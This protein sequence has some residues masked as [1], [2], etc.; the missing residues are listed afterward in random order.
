MSQTYGN[1]YTARQKLVKLN[2]QVNKIIVKITK[3]MYLGQDTEDGQQPKHYHCVEI[4]QS[5]AWFGYILHEIGNRVRG[6]R[7]T[8]APL[9]E[10]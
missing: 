5:A 7:W 1:N 2:Y 9:S 6:C 10:T 4:H 8:W 3:S